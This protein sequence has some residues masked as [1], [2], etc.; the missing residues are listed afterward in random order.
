MIYVINVTSPGIDANDLM[1]LMLAA[2]SG[3]W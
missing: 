2:A 3:G 1:Y